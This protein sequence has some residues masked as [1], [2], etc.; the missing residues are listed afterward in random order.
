MTDLGEGE[1]WLFVDST[2][3][4]AVYLNGNLAGSVGEWMRTPCGVH[5]LRL[6]KKDPPRPGAS[7]PTWLDEGDSLVIPCR[8][9]TAVTAPAIP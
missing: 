5:F 2:A 1:G 3:P 8:G 9:S 4:L 7:F 6:A